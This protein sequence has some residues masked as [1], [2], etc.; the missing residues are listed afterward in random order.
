MSVRKVVLSATQY[1]DGDAHYNAQLFASDLVE[2]VRLNNYDVIIIETSN[3][4]EL[5]CAVKAIIIARR[6]IVPYGF[7]L[8]F[9]PYYDLEIGEGEFER[10]PIE[11]TTEFHEEQT[12]ESEENIEE[13]ETPLTLSVVI[14]DVLHGAQVQT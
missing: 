13:S 12:D 5:N 11:I 7:E 10:E 4:G 14:V 2:I 3:P 8:F 6:K 1:K 9:R